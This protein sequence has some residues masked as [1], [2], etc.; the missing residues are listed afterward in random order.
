MTLNGVSSHLSAEFF[1]FIF[2]LFYSVNY[3]LYIIH[4]FQIRT[5][6]FLTRNQSNTMGGSQ[7]FS[8]CVVILY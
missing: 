4:W 3:F 1:S 6:C 5:V 8:L 7:V 2:I